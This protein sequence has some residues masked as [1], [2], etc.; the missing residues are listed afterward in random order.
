MS[1]SAPI[2]DPSRSDASGT[3]SNFTPSND[4]RKIICACIGTGKAE[5]RFTTKAALY[6]AGRAIP[7][8]HPSADGR[9]A[10]DDEIARNV[11]ETQHAC[12]SHPPAISVHGIEASGRR[13]R[14]I[15][16]LGSEAAEATIGRSE[17]DPV[18][19]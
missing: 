17:M 15:H 3:T 9:M 6:F 1:A 14:L 8:F 13:Q 11:S 12:R 5:E 2:P 4:P 7:D 10:A 18:E 19:S 16:F